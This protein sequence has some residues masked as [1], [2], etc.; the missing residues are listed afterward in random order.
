M[1]DAL[2]VISS[3]NEVSIIG[4]NIRPNPLSGKELYISGSHL[5]KSDF[6]IIDI[7][8]KT[9]QRGI[10]KGNTINTSLYLPGLYFIQIYDN[11]SL[12]SA[13]FIKE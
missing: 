1:S 8:G 5:D 11:K 10:V 9:I 7:N 3:N 4:L 13:R 12:Y 2:D 6:K